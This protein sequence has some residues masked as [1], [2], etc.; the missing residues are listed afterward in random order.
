[1]SMLDEEAKAL[2]RENNMLLKEL[3]ALI[4]GMNSPQANAREFLMNYIANKLSEE[5]HITI[6]NP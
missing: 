2:I 3:L 5:K 6:K 1:M 4:R